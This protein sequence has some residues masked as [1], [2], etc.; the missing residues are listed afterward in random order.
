MIYFIFVS[1]TWV[2]IS[3]WL[4]I[5]SYVNHLCHEYELVTHMNVS[6]HIYEWIMSHTWTSHVT[7]VKAPCYRKRVMSRIWMGQII[8]M[9]E[10]CH[11]CVSPVLRDKGRVTNMS[12]GHTY[13]Q[14]VRVTHMNNTCHT[15]ENQIYVKRVMS[16]IWMNHVT[17]TNGS[18]HTY[19]WVVLHLWMG[20]GTHMNESRH[21]HERVTSRTWTSH[22]THVNESSHTCQ[23]VKSHMSMS[24]VT[25]V[26]ESCHTCQWVMSQTWIHHQTLDE[27]TA[28]EWYATQ[29]ER[30]QVQILQRQF[31]MQFTIE[32][33]CQGHF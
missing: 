1:Q 13:E 6:C 23:W 7:R 9:N 8:H 15:C 10:T 22:V 30:V 29:P 21:T 31:A 25:H 32:N 4:I 5:D 2:L 11:T 16:H 12:H 27:Q 19:K 24:Q 3:V 20:Q 18:C 33:D 26:N 17:H 14:F 28:V